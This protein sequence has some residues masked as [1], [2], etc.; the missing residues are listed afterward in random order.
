MASDPVWGDA[1][2]LSDRLERMARHRHVQRLAS[3]YQ[4]G[5]LEP[6]LA[7]GVTRLAHS[8]GVAFLCM[9]AARGAG[10]PEDQAELLGAAGLL[11]DIGHGPLSHTY[12]LATETDHED[13]SRL[14]AREVVG[15]VEAGLPASHQAYVLYLLGEGGEPELPD[16]WLPFGPALRA[17]VA[18]PALDMDRIDYVLRDS[19][20][21]G[22]PLPAT[23]DEVLALVRSVRC[24]P[25]GLAFSAQHAHTLGRIASHRHRLWIEVYGCRAARSLDLA[26]ADAMRATFPT[27][28][29][30]D[31]FLALTDA[32]VWH[33]LR[34]HPGVGEAM[35]R[36]RSG[37]TDPGEGRPYDAQCVLLWDADE[38]TCSFL[39][40]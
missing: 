32:M 26:V 4:L 14:L 8:R 28:A 37:Q 12:D 10:C 31:T 27:L 35:R 16:S 15:D 23:P 24:G 30:K 21:L 36:L 22:L 17:L 5:A 39:F 1:L 2:A 3:V 18:S 33:A 6:V 11:H 13:R 34:T 38:W 9:E 40:L 20:G 19:L 25:E 7:T 29:A